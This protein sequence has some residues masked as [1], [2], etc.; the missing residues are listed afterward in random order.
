MQYIFHLQDTVSGDSTE[1]H[2]NYEYD[3]EGVL[4]QWLEGNYSCDCNRS[5]FLWN[6][7]ET[8]HLPCNMGLNQIKLT[9]IIRPDGT[10]VK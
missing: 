6:W 8:K 7:D 4:Y 3:E 2:D 5:L 9:K 10:E 1:Y